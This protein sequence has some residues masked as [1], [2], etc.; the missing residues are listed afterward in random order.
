M[1]F[2]NL[3]F[4]ATNCCPNKQNKSEV[5]EELN[6]KGT[7]PGMGMV[8]EKPAADGCLWHEMEGSLCTPSASCF[9]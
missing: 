3:Q 9:S 8:C 6:K 4:G 5:W 2:D 1:L 7:V